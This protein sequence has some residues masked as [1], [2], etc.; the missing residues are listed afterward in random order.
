LLKLALRER[1]EDGGVCVPNESPNDLFID[2]GFTSAQRAL[3]D[4]QA[5]NPVIVMDG[6]QG[7]L[8]LSVEALTPRRLDSL[9]AIA[10]GK[11]ALTVSGTKVR[12]NRLEAGAAAILPLSE[13]DGCQQIMELA[14]GGGAFLGRA[15]TQADTH[16]AAIVELAKLCQL[17]PAAVTIPLTPDTEWPPALRVACDDVLRFRAA[18]ADSLKLVSRA[19]VA[20]RWD[21]DSEFIV[22]RDALGATWTAVVIGNPAFDEPVPVRMH[23]SCLTGD[24]FGSLRCDCGDQLRMSIEILRESGGVLLYLDQEGCGIGLANKMRAYALQDSGLD[25]IDANMALGFESDERRYD[26]AARMLALLG[27]RQVTLLTNNPSK[28][29]GLSEA[30]IAILGR[31]PLIAPVNRQN[32]RYLDAKARR[33]GHLL[34]ESHDCAKH[35]SGG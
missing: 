27:I 7:S 12:H 22:F 8:A 34:H 32:R 2:A 18:C 9:R 35:A 25:T 5:G 24:S 33:A 29:S 6:S 1:A 3:A 23:S 4:F 20:L 16:G 26:I 17:L 19:R 11:P 31:I 14:V 10:G 21:V 13:T 28:V 15:V 30:G